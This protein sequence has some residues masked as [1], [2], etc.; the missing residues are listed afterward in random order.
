MKLRSSLVLSRAEET[1]IEEGSQ[2]HAKEGVSGRTCFCWQTSEQNEPFKSERFW[3]TTAGPARLC[4]HE[5]WFIF[6]RN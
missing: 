4:F 5:A 6:Q 1:W 3:R 2:V